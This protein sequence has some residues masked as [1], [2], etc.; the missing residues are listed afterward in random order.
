MPDHSHTLWIDS[1][2]ETLRSQKHMVEQAIE[3]ID[4]KALHRKPGETFNS[5]AII[6][7]HL[8]GNMLS[9]WPDFLIA[10]GE[11]PE[12]NRD[13]E[14]SD[15]TGNRQELLDYWQRGWEAVFN[16][17]EPLSETDIQKTIYIRGEPMSVPRAI[18][19]QIAHYGYHVGQI[20]LLAR[21]FTDP[22]KWR[23]LT[24]APKASAA[25]NQEHWGK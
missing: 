1:A 2:V 22:K 13:M 6:M 17:I 23:W 4:D 10:D 12:R 5:I 14:F 20:V 16:A 15:W 3:Q 9:R 25:Y 11:K 8:S 21:L 7:R 19:R 18:D 24:I